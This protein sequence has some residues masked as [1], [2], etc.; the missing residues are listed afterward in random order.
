[1]GYAPAQSLKQSSSQLNFHIALIMTR[2]SKH[3]CCNVSNTKLRKNRLRT[4]RE[5]DQ[6]AQFYPGSVQ[7]IDLRLA[8]LLHKKTQFH[9]RELYTLNLT[10]LQETRNSNLQETNPE[11]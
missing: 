4:K 11:V 7:Y 6:H 3:I 2:F 5:Q 1:M 10:R 9:Y 8:E